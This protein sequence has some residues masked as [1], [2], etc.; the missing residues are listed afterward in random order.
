MIV[1]VL[2]PEVGNLYGDLA[3]IEYLGKCTDIKIVNTKINEEPYFVNN[4]VDLIYMGSM[5]ESHQ[6]IVIKKL[7]K[8]SKKIQELI[9]KGTFFLITGN[10]LEVFGKYIENEDGTKIDGLNVFNYYSKRDFSSHHASHVLGEFNGIKIVGDKSQFSHTYDNR[11]KFIECI[12]GKGL[13]NNSI[14]EGIKK[15][16]F[17]ATYLIGPF[18][19]QNPLFVK[20]LLE[21]MNV[22]YSLAFENDILESYRRRLKDFED[23]RMKF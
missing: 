1:N 22:K 23:K 17:Y 7:K 19:I 13:D 21:E 11:N 12:K 8:Y 20:Y 10:A 16:N 5:M 6:E 2:Y 18:L 9:K 3:N 15:N 4:K 14:Y